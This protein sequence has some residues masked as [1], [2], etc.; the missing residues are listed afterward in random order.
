MLQSGRRVGLHKHHGCRTGLLLWLL[1]LLRTLLLLLLLL[2][3][4]WLL[5]PLLEHHLRVDMVERFLFHDRCPPRLLRHD[6]QNYLSVVLFGVYSRCAREGG[7]KS[8]LKR[9]LVWL[10]EDVGWRGMRGVV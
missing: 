2:L 6:I 8:I 5:L 3:W 10:V 1:L 7:K 4:L 9:G